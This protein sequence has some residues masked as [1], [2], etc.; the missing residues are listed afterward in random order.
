[1][2]ESALAQEVICR[3]QNQVRW[4]TLDRPETRNG[5]SLDVVSHLTE[6]L[7]DSA[8]DDSVRVI[9]IAGANGSFCSGLDLKSVMGQPVDFDDAMGK[10]HGLTLKLRS[11]LKPTLAAID[12]PAAGFGANMALACDLRWATEQ[13]S[14]GQKFVKIGLMPD[15]GG[16]FFLP[17]AVG[18]G[19]AFELMYEGEMIDAK[20][21]LDFG[22]VNQVLPQDNF[23]NEVQ[24]YA[25]KLAQG[26][27]LAYA[28]LKNS[29]LENSGDLIAAL[30]VEEKGQLEL[31]RSTDFMEGVSAFL[32]KRNPNFKGR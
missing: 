23:E 26:P 21:A 5:L 15:G 18:L 19:K 6:I 4:I 30:K 16:T 28:R 1:M 31:M 12:G 3:D 25:E 7:H 29:L 17:R 8:A 32:E 14:F 27:P 20:S 11:V 2:S 24:K 22:I 9:V 13:A 10:F